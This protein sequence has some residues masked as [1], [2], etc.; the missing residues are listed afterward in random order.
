MARPR[1][2]A[3]RPDPRHL[4]RRLPSLGRALAYESLEDRRL[5]AIDVHVR[6][7]FANSGGQP[8]ETLSVGDDFF[9]NAYVQD[10]RTSAAGVFQAYL[11]VEYAAGLVSTPGPVSHGFFYNAATAG[12]V[13]TPGLIDDAGGL[14]TDQ[15]APVPTNAELLLFSVPFHANSAGQLNLSAALPQSPVHQVVLFDKVGGT[16]IEN[17]QFVGGSIEIDAAPSPK[18]SIATTQGG[19]ETGPTNGVFTVSQSIT[20]GSNTVVQY[21]VSGTATSG[22]D[23]TPLSGTAT[24]LAGQASTTINVPVINDGLVEATE[25]V[26]V[27]LNSISQGD[28]SVSIDSGAKSATLNITDNDSAQVS[29]AAT[30]GGNETGP[31][32]GR[33][34]VTQSA[35]SSTNTVISFSLGGSATSGSDYS[36]IPTSVTILAGNTTATVDVPVI[37]DSLIEGTET[38][39]ATLTAITSGDPQITLQP[40]GTQATLSIADNDTAQV[41]VAPTTDGDEAGTI[42][43]VFTVTQTAVSPSNTVVTYMLS[44]SAT[45]GSDYTAPSGS[46]TI[47]AGTTSATITVPVIDDPIVE[48]DETVIVTLGTITSGNPQVS[49]DPAQN[50]ATLTIADNDSAQVRIAKTSDGSEDGPV[51]GLFTVT[52]TATSSIATTISYTVG[53]TAT[54]GSDYTALSGT[55][56]IP[57]GQTSATIDVPVIDDS[58]PEATE[59]VVVTLSSITSGDPQIQIDSGQNQAT[60]QIADNEA[61]VVRI[62]KTS[63]ADEDGPVDGL[64]TVSQTMVMATD[65]VVAYVVTGTATSGSDFTPLSGTVTILAGQMS[66]PIDVDVLD[67]ELIEGT[68]TV[69]VTLTEITAGNPSLQLD[70]AKSEATVNL[71]DNETG[72]VSIVATMDGAESGPVDGLFTVTQDGIAA[73]DTVISYSVAGSATAGD[74]YT[75]LS[76]T[77]TILAGQTSAT[78]TVLVADDALVEPDETVVVTLSEVTEGSPLV[79][80]NPAQQEATVAIADDDTAEVRIDSATGGSEDG[81]TGGVITIVQ[82]APSSTDTVVHYSIGGTATN[83]DDYAALGG[84]VTIL[85]GATSATIDLAVVDDGVVEATETVTITLLSLDT[86]G[87]AVTID[88]ENDD[89]TVEITDND[90]ALASVEKTS[91]G[92]ETGPAGIVFTVS[93]TAPSSTDTEIQYTLGG[94]ATAGSDYTAPSGTVV[95]P[96]GSTSRPIKIA[97]IDD[98]VLEDL[99]TVTIVLDTISGDPE[100]TIDPVADSAAAD[101]VDNETGLISI[102]ATTDGS[103]AG[104]TAGQ[105]T[106]SQNGTTDVDTVIAYAV[107]GT[108]SSGDDYVALSGTVTIPAGQTTATIDV[109]VLDDTLI[110]GNETVI[111]TLTEITSG[112]ARLAIDSAADAA[113]MTIVEDDTGLVRIAPD[114]D[115]AE[116]GPTSG[117]FLVSQSGIA[118]VDTVVSYTVSGTA[119][120]GS[121]FTALSGTVTILAGQTSAAIVLEAIDDNIVEA[122]ESVIVTLTGITSGSPLVTVDAANDMATV[123]IEDNDSATVSLSATSGGSEAGPTSGVFTVTQSA[124]SSTDTVISYTVGGTAASGSDYTALAGT[125]AILAGQTSATVSVPVIDDS[126]VEGTE[127]VTLALATISQGDADITI[128]ASQ[129]EASLQIAD[130]DNATISFAAATSSV[131]EFVGSHTVVVRLSIPGGGT[132]GQSVTVNVSTTGG[133]ATSADFSLSTTSVTFAAGSANGAEQTVGLVITDDGVLEP[134]ETVVLGLA[135]GADGT[136]G[137]AAI[138]N[139]ASHTVTIIDDP[140]TGVISGFVWADTNWNGTRDAGEI[141]IPGVTVHLSGVDGMGQSVE[142]TTTTDSDGAYSFTDLAIGTYDVTEEQPAAFNDSAESLGTIDGAASGTAGDDR[143]TGISMTP[144]GQGTDYNF[145]ESGLKAQYVNVRFFL[146]TTPKHDF[147]LRDTIFA[148][149]ARATA[150]SAAQSLVAATVPAAAS[151]A[152]AQQSATP[153]IT[154]SSSTPSV[155]SDTPETTPSAAPAAAANTAT[156]VLASTATQSAPSAEPAAAPSAVPASA[157]DASV[158][159]FLA[160]AQ[161][162]PVV[163][164]EANINDVAFA[165]ALADSD[166]SGDSSAVA[167]LVAVADSNDDA[168]AEPAVAAML[169]EDPSGD[170]GIAGGSSEDVQTADQALEQEESWLDQLVA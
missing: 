67:D 21:T 65:T 137:R 88:Q 110:E 69:V 108:A 138:G 6:F 20:T 26:I 54:A 89:A 84:T 63:D 167:A 122:T 148:A 165:A 53:G 82:T 101:L 13:S 157:D 42:S 166:S 93:L 109:T 147:I 144:G 29:I 16:P 25:T 49:I 74:D 8:V 106:V 33:F 159:G 117:A 164:T 156:Q 81:P 62:A 32:A 160:S 131:I 140:E 57:A 78:I 120:S 3:F 96:A 107:T 105:F 19:S 150:L 127:T 85:A 94:T 133:T 34:T 119:S 99:E 91:D 66:A 30:T 51:G 73:A 121:D 126:V 136:G 59:T 139:L 169:L 2:G 103:E 123:T 104:P 24:I 36:N 52:Q 125:V 71:A 58:E 118:G 56:T 11:D 72:L 50:Q 22:S 40:G 39:I 18:V 76:G 128:D 7:E 43:G 102:A 115:A 87:A 44:G 170:R 10:V 17:I 92:N 155:E 142:R 1:R 55:V 135:I 90:T 86:G 70:A 9:I 141:A 48:S 163:D 129:D 111:V 161:S 158:R 113:T 28:P 77:V 68:E 31:A 12:S 149:Q 98:V 37:D 15:V 95:I 46:V 5:L 83:G 168:L 112:D 116:S 23:F 79:G 114:G 61:P 153:Q 60:V 124:V 64:F 47:V 152:V 146:A 38:V 80:I 4:Q 97:V 14:D 134:A 27:T 151:Q 75:A 154:T 143:F 132:L 45:A 35:A 100:I 162:E 130:N 41:R 145:G